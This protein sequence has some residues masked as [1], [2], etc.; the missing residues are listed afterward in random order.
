[1]L[2]EG[3][4]GGGAGVKMRTSSVKMII[5]IKKNKKQ[6]RADGDKKRERGITVINE[7][8]SHETARESTSSREYKVIKTVC[9]FC[10][11]NIQRD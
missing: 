9:A 5:I 3:G 10:F 6:V 11:R 1:M 2:I 8:V 4:A 7:N